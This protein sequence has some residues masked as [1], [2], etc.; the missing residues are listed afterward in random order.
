M[1][2]KTL[3][4]LIRIIDDDEALLASSAL[5]LRSMG[6]E[7]ETWSDG[8]SFLEAESLLR[9]GCIIL[10][11]QMPGMDGL[12][13]QAELVR[14]GS[15][16][17]VLFLTAHGSIPLAVRAL[18]RGAEDFLE[19]PV[20]SMTL[21][22]RVAQCATASAARSAEESALSE[23]RA[24][25]ESLTPRERDVAGHV[26]KNEANKEIA[27]ALGLEVSTVKMHRANA[28]AKL[29]VHSPGELWQLASECGFTGEGLKDPGSIP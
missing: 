3:L 7:V 13:V 4:P 26:L 29:G 27:R 8:A 12:E 21:V 23:K 25:F 18:H 9:P 20:D 24:R 14:R 6:W 17:P 2:P 1:T 19:K 15:R 16:L 10:D 28:F 5:L 22:A 11:V